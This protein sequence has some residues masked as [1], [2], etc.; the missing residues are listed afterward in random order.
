[1]TYKPPTKTSIYRALKFGDMSYTAFMRDIDNMIFVAKKRAYGLGYDQGHAAGRSE[2]YHRGRNN[3][4][5][6][7]Y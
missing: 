6:S 3:P 2:G 7:N 5:P 1:M 4:I